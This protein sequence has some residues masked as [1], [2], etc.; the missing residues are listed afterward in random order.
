MTSQ[1]SPAG[2]VA[3]A[4]VGIAPPFG[5][6]VR[7]LR[8]GRAG[9]VVAHSQGGLLCRVRLDGK[10]GAGGTVE[11]SGCELVPVESRAEVA[12]PPPD[13]GPEEVRRDARGLRPVSGE[14]RVVPV[15]ASAAAGVPALPAG[16]R[17]AASPTGHATGVAARSRG[18]AWLTHRGA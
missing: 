13:P 8:D 1:S 17:D 11:C 18:L 5:A 14:V 3:P 10:A 6:E 2:P 4:R 12:G 15:A 9:R 7:L 16:P